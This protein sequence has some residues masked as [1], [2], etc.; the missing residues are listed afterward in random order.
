[1]SKC[2]GH[3][4][5]VG[6]RMKSIV[7]TVA[8]ALCVVGPVSGQGPADEVV[9]MQA[10][11]RSFEAQHR[12]KVAVLVTSDRDR[13]ASDIAVGLGIEAR[14]DSLVFECHDHGRRCRLNDADVA[15]KWGNPVISGDTAQVQVGLAFGNRE[16][17]GPLYQQIW[18]VKLIRDRG[19][20]KVVDRELIIET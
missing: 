17:F 15:F 6:G 16:E 20:W 10:A 14:R 5:D 8:L 12:D 1:M 18:N 13:R 4:F 3:M 19:R 9:I 7:I 2:A 11:L